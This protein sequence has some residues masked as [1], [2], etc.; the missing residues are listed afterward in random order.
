MSS[1]LL[2]ALD[3]FYDTNLF[4]K[5]FWKLVY[6]WIAVRQPHA[7]CMMNYGY[8]E[9]ESTAEDL[10]GE[11]LCR[12]LYLHVAGAIDLEG[13]TL[14]EVG[15]GRGGGLVHVKQALLPKTA[16]GLELSPR[17]VAL[18]RRLYADVPGISFFQGD[19]EDIPFSD[20][21]FD[22]VLNVESSHCYPSLGRFFQEVRR[23]LVPGGSFLYA[24]FFQADKLEAVREGLLR[25][26]FVIAREKDITQPVLRALRRDEARK[27]ALI[28]RE[29]AWRRGALRNFAATTDSRTYAEL[30][31]GT[32]RYICFHL[33]NLGT[34]SSLQM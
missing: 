33:E 22:A 18:T 8:L 32:R 27:L 30:A 25:T 19:A 1:L 5:H 16:F 20:A 23:V 26:P 17:A 4:R 34:V 9:D 6:D 28:S 14:L 3:A 7:F 21:C 13:K 24:D 2:S 12:R 11:E 29:P 31:C 15:A 10:A